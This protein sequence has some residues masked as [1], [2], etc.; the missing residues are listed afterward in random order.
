MIN[1]IS[2]QWWVTITNTSGTTTMDKQ[3]S[4]LIHTKIV[5]KNTD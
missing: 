3:I 4:Q 5:K 2:T 1:I